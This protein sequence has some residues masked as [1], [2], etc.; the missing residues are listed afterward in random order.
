MKDIPAAATVVGVPG[1]VVVKKDDSS[2]SAQR[3]AMAKKIG[4]AAYAESKEVADPIQSALDSILD[5][6]HQVESELAELKQEK[7]NE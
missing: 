4:F 6:L 7:E 2:K 3:E 5:H 1:H